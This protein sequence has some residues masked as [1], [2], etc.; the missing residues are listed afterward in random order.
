VLSLCFL[1]SGPV[2]GCG[3][4]IN[5]TSGTIQSLDDN[6]D[7]IYET[8]LNCEWQIIVPQNSS[9]SLSFT[10]FNLA[11]VGCY[12]YLEVWL[13]ACDVEEEEDDAVDIFIL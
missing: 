5:S 4:L 8:D 3:G 11:P 1:D 12:D 13:K 2:S 6:R 9:V 10:R 7:G